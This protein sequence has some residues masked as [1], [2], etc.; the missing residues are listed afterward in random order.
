[1]LT[2][3]EVQAQKLLWQSAIGGT[4][5][6]NGMKMIPVDHG[7]FIM[8]GKTSSNDGLGEGNHKVG[9]YDIVVARIS[10]KGQII[11]Q[12]VIGG[13]ENEEFEDMILTKDGGIA[14]MGTTLSNDG[15]ITDSHGKM[16]FVLAKL[17][18]MGN[19]EWVRC[20]GGGGNDQG[21]A[22]IELDGG[23]FL[24]G[25]E[26]GSRNGNMTYSHG[27]LDAWVAIVGPDGKVESE[28]A[29]GGRSNERVTHLLELKTDRYL[30]L[31]VT[32]SRGGD[33]KDPLGAKDVWALCLSK[34]F[35]IIW[36]RTYGG[37]DFDEPHD[38]IRNHEGNLVI[39]GTTF[40]DDQ[41]LDLSTNHGLG[42]S[43]IFEI[44]S[45]GA[46]RW[47]QCFG[48][49]KS[50]GA[51]GIAETPDRGYIMVGTSNSK[52]KLVPTNKG[53]YD[54]W[55]VKVDSLGKKVWSGTFGGEDFEYLYDVVPLEGGNYL[56]LGFAESVKGDLLPLN[57]DIGNDFWFFRFSDPDDDTDNEITSSNYLAGSVLSK[58][59][60]VALPAT[61]TVTNNETVSLVEKA[62]NEKG[63]GH[64]LIDLPEK[65][66]YSVM[67]SAP[68]Y[69]FYGQDLDFG[70]LAASPEIRIDVFLEP[71][72]V[73]SK[74]I[75]NNIYFNTG[76][77]D[78]KSE[79]EPELKRLQQFL[80]AN[81]NVKVEISGHTDDTGNPDSKRKLSELRASR[82][83][84]W[85]LKAGIPG[86]QMQVAGY[87]MDRPVVE[88]VDKASRAKNRR[89]EV[90]VVELL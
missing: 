71:I 41:D 88:N 47:S 8:A 27:G 79:S 48:G 36:Q 4:G 11:W 78:V 9:N 58:N 76:K 51:N 5:Y 16:D 50:E 24:I 85:L 52:D 87:G 34:N 20:Y 29:F 46:L 81:P 54:G 22:V 2:T 49:G 43:W 65:G 18:K 77:Y 21:K 56:A 84:D 69:M 12:T 38:I 72:L 64:Y 30:A 60:G 61:I 13:S 45:Q 10:A 17:D 74:V 67:F 70:L 66:N 15:D 83:R 33:V 82:V 1:F 7:C 31:C 59:T 68:G 19:K 73:G 26:S 28:K 55:I 3:D 53:L 37:S 89:V 35:D 25:G 63:T 6:D 14:V 90:E 86:K 32:N 75:L 40:S 23:R 44:S 39:A 57:K 42:D 80:K 62:K